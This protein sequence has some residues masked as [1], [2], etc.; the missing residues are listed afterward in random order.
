MDLYL[1]G[2]LHFGL[3]QAGIRV[4]IREGG[5]DVTRLL[6]EIEIRGYVEGVGSKRGVSMYADQVVPNVCVFVKVVADR[7]A[8]PV[9]RPPEEGFVLRFQILGL[10]WCVE[11][12]VV[13]VV[14]Q[15]AVVFGRVRV[16]LV[17]GA[18]LKF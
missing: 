3:V 17:R 14:V 5:C 18:A 2:R 4:L 8:G 7:G 13:S 11:E 15:A 9:P 12:R 1:C 10:D 6:S 16:R